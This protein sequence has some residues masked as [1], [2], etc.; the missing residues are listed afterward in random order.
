MVRV[1]AIAYTSEWARRIE[2]LCAER[3]DV[4]ISRLTFGSEN[5]LEQLGHSSAQIVAIE[6]GPEWN[7]V[8]DV[9]RSIMEAHPLPVV[10]LVTEER[11]RATP[12]ADESLE[13]G[14]LSVLTIPAFDERR[15]DQALAEQLAKS[16]RLMAEIKVVRRWD[17]AKLESL[18]RPM[19]AQPVAVRHEHH[20]DIIAVGASAGGTKAL[21]EVFSH[22]PH[23]FPLP[24]LVVQHIAKGYLHG[25]ARWLGEQTALRVTIAENG[26]LLDG[27]TVY[28]APDDVHLTVDG[29]H[30]ILLADDEPINGF[31]PSI[32]RLFRSIHESYGGH[33]IAVLLSG[34]GNDGAQEMR[35]LH[36]AGAVTIAQDKATSLIHGIPG[37][38]IKLAAVSSVLPIQEIGPALLTLSALK[39]A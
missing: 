8:R 19:P 4:Q 32:D 9:T 3:D 18:S 7:R 12:H 25:L 20:L 30:R 26:C 33:A 27:G 36:L 35:R 5:V 21:Q 10:I 2:C 34:M 14:A 23:E 1:F 6:G 15:D 22:L 16:L 11:A 38:A 17:S 39:H 29:K 24:V 37:E 13:A 28:L 31:K